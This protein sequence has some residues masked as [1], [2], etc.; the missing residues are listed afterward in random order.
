MAEDE[1]LVIRQRDGAGAGQ[2]A[3]EHGK[4]IPVALQQAE[5]PFV[6]MMIHGCLLT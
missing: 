1:T 3:A 2:D 5:I 4:G 6:G